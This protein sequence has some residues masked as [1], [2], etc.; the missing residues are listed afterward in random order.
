MHRNM[1]QNK[2]AKQI[3]NIWYKNIHAFLRYSDFRVGTFYVA[4]PCTSY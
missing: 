4:S 1:A 3:S 2:G